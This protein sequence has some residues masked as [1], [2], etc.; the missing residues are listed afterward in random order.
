MLTDHLPDI[1]HR[2]EGTVDDEPRVL[3]GGRFRRGPE[4][5]DVHRLRSRAVVSHFLFNGMLIARRELAEFHGLNMAVAT[6]EDVV[7]SKLEWAKLRESQRQ[8]ED[9]A[10]LLRVRAGE[11]DRDYLTHWIK[12]LGLGKQWEAAQRMAGV[13]TA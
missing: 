7:L 12:E 11:L 5:V 2:L 3:D 4:V 10:S 9:T 13:E 8:L 6:V 1:G